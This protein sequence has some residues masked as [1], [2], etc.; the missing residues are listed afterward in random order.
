M[1]NTNPDE[2]RLSCCIRLCIQLHHSLHRSSAHGRDFEN[3]VWLVLE[4]TQNEQDEERSGSR[5]KYIKNQCMDI[6]AVNWQA[7]ALERDRLTSSITQ[8][9][10]Q[11]V[12]QKLRG[13]EAFGFKCLYIEMIYWLPITTVCIY[14]DNC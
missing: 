1:R 4:I 5:G 14:A 12:D 11:V 7:K 2:L 6:Y 3:C 13:L 8:I 9:T 10:C